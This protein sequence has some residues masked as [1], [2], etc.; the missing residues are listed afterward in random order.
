MA[1]PKPRRQVARALRHRCPH[2]RWRAI[3]T[4]Q[5]GE[6]ARAGGGGP[7]TS[8]IQRLAKGP[9]QHPPHAA[10]IAEAHLGLGRMHVDVDLA[11]RHRHEQRE[12]RVARLGDQIAVGRA[13]GADQQLVLHR[14]A[15]DEEVLLAG[16]GPMQRRQPGKAGDAHALALDFDRQRVVQELAPHDAAETREM[17]VGAQGL[18]R[19]S[20]A[21][22][23]PRRQREGDRRVRHGE[24]LDDLGDRGVLGA[25]AF[26]ELEP[27]RRR[28]EQ[29]A[30][31]DAGAGVE[32]G[33][34]HGALGA[35][36]DD[37][38]V[39]RPASGLAR[40]DRQMRHRADRG[41]RL[42]AEAERGNVEEVLVGEL[43]GGVALDRQLEVGRAHAR[44]VVGDADEGEPAR[45]RHH[46]D[47]G[48]ARVERVLDRA[49]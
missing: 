26:E 42:A 44:A 23:L 45:R 6:A 14:P 43:G 41:Q 1:S 17:S 40:P 27:R 25:L 49:P 35:A 5:F 8:T 38:L 13:H 19:Q 37:D 28:R 21:R 12:Q 11:R 36:I 15:V 33:G 31:L 30:H 32:G 4:R 16:V 7:M 9:N 46:L 18:R 24:A 47:V 39:R 3:R 22:A 2:A 10:R 29:L 34:P 20:Q 48:R